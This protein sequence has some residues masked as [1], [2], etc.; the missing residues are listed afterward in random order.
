ML[1]LTFDGFMTGFMMFLSL[2]FSMGVFMAFYGTFRLIDRICTFYYFDKP[3]FQIISLEVF[4]H[5][6]FFNTTTLKNVI[7]HYGHLL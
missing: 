2:T 7:S 5:R 1:D 4:V 6:I 3:P